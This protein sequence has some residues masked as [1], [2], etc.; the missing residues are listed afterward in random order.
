MAVS[1]MSFF[2]QLMGFSETTGPE[3]R[4]QLT[5]DGS[6]LTSMVNGSSYEAGRLTIPA[7]RD[8]RRTGLPTTGRSTVREVVADVQALHLLP[9]NA[10]AFFQV[11]SQFNLL[12]MDKPNRTPEEG[13]GIYQHDRTQGPACAIACGAATIYRNWLVPVDGQPGQTEQRQIDCIA[14]LGEAFG[15]G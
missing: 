4:A 13:V 9:E 14:D 7:L 15:G 6:T 1:A 8:L 5:L 10:G 11:A 12:E 2:E 3:I